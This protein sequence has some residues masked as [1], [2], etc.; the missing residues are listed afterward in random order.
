MIKDLATRA[1][2]V[3]EHVEGISHWISD[4][5][6]RIP[7]IIAQATRHK[8]VQ[9]EV[10]SICA[11]MTIRLMQLE[12]VMAVHHDYLDRV[13]KTSLLFRITEVQDE[14]NSVLDCLE[15]YIAAEAS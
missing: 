14:I 5:E 15:I 7:Q 4:L 9:Q 12:A 3:S 8:R 11:H 2:A 10:S 6:A 13:G 1:D